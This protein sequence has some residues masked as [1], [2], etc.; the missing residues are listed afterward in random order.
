MQTLNPKTTNLIASAL[1][2]KKILTAFPPE[3][4]K[5]EETAR[6]FLDHMDED[7]PK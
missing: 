5:R 1:S 4:W 3:D 2:C 6:T 7:S